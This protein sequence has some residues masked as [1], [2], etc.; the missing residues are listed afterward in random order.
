MKA[1]MAAAADKVQEKEETTK[2]SVGSK[3]IYK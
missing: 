3:N 1:S 2:E